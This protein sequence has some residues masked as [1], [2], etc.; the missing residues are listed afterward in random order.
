MSSTT[1]ND[2]PPVSKIAGSL[3]VDKAKLKERRDTT[4][5]DKAAMRQRVR[6]QLLHELLVALDRDFGKCTLAD[7]EVAKSA[8][9]DAY[10][11]IMSIVLVLH[12]QGAP[13]ADSPPAS[14]SDEDEMEEV[15]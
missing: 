4:K 3:R 14:G 5:A 12:E 7:L 15:N 6:G 9:P 1:I 13:V 10:Y 2:L 11:Q 8:L